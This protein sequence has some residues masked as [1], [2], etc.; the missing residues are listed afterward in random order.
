MA[1]TLGTGILWQQ[2]TIT[3]FT[4]KYLLESLNCIV[5]V[6]EGVHAVVHHHEPA[7]GGGE[8]NIGVPGKPEDGDMVVPEIDKSCIVGHFHFLN[9]SEDDNLIRIL[10]N[11]RRSVAASSKQ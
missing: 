6:H 11:V 4:H 2:M 1:S 3:I 8:L 5:A 10:T 7:A 9:K